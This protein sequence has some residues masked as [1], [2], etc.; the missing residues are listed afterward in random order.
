MSLK[1]IKSRASEPTDSGDSTNK[2]DL[3]NVLQQHFLD[4]Q[5]MGKILMKIGINVKDLWS[6][7]KLW[8]LVAPQDQKE[9]T[10]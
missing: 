5:E 4:V 7:R 3:D 1:R 9:V 10:I 8:E 2:S 6:F